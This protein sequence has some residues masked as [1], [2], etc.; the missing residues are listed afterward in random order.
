[1]QAINS[2]GETITVRTDTD[3]R[4]QFRG[5]DIGKWLIVAQG[6]ALGFRETP[7]TIE[8]EK[9]VQLKF[10]LIRDEAESAYQVDS[11]IVVEER[12][13]SS[14]LTERFL[15]SEDIS[16]LPGSG[17]DVVKAIQNIETCSTEA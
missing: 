10:Y 12:A 5:L 2:T 13:D 8:K 15:R 4:F 9:V 14:E 6:P 17:G 16:Y 7:I 1:M 3:G 11:E